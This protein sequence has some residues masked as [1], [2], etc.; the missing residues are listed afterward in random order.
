MAVVR[1]SGR[2]GAPAKQE[3]TTRSKGKK[4][5]IHSDS[6]SDGYDEAPGSTGH[7][8]ENGANGSIQDAEGEYDEEEGGEG[9][10][11][12]VRGAKRQRVDGQ[13]A[14]RASSV[15]E[16][17]QYLRIKT[18][19]RDTDGY[20]PGS[21]MRIQLK[22]FV[23]YDFVQFRCGPYLN[24][25]LGPN[26]TG[27]SSIA[28][29]IALGL[30]FP[31]SILGRANEL[32][33]FVK[34]GMESGYIEIE[35]KGP[36]GK[37]NY[38][39]RRHINAK[40][41]GSTFTLNGQSVAAKEV[42]TKVQELNV[43]VSNLCSFLPQDKVSEFAAMT[44]QQLLRETQRAAGDERLTAWHDTLINSGRELKVV[45]DKVNEEQDHMRLLRE[46][47][48]VV[49]RD[50][51]RFRERKRIEHDISLLEVL[52]PVERYRKARKK[53]MDTKA[54]QRLL[55]T[56]VAMLKE[57]N[58]PVIDLLNKLEGNSKQRERERENMKRCTKEKFGQML[59]QW[60]KCEK[61]DSEADDLTSRIDQRKKDENDRQRRIRDLEKDIAQI[62]KELAAPVKTEDPNDLDK[63]RRQVNQERA[64][65][66]ARKEKIE[67]DV[68][69][70]VDSSSRKQAEVEVAQ[71]ELK[72]LDD[73][74]E[75]KLQNM[76]NWD[77]DTH[78]VILWLRKN[79]H[80]FKMPI[81]EP[82]AIL[83]NVPNK[84]FV[85]PVEA[86]FNSAQLRTFVA[87]CQE[88]LDLFNK[89]VND[90][91]GREFGRKVRVTT[92]FRP[93]RE[94]QLTRPPMAEEELR[95]EGFD[96]YA[97][98]YVDCPKE[99]HWFLK[100]EVNLHRTAIALRP[101]IDVNNVMRLVTRDGPNGAGGGANFFNGATHNIVTRSRY[102][103]RAVAN[104]T[105]EIRPGRTLRAV[106]IDPEV[107][108]RYDQTIATAQQ[109]LAILDEE[110]AGLEADLNVVRQ[111]D[112][113]IEDKLT[114]IKR[115]KDAI[116]E[117]Q[118]RLARLKGKL[119][120]NRRR[121]NELIDMPPLNE[122][123]AELRKN[124]YDLS[125]KRVGIIRE[126][127][128]IVKAVVNEQAECC[129]LGLE[130]LQIS[131]NK[132]ALKAEW[133]KKDERYQQEL[134][135]FQRVDN[136]YKRVKQESKE[137]LEQSRA[138]VAGMEPDL[139][140][141][142]DEIERKRMEYDKA[143]HAAE[144][145]GT[146]S[147]S[148]EGVDVRSLEELQ[149]ELETQKA[150]LE[151]NLATNPHVIEQYERRKEEIE[152]LERTIEEKR[153]RA[154]RFEKNIKTARDNWE[155]AL[156]KLIA[157]IG[158]KFSAAFDRI[159]C[160]GEI[161]ISQH[162]DYDK[163]AID[164]LVKFRDSEKLQ[165]LTGQRQSGGE[166]SLTTILYLMSLTEE[167]RAPFSLVD[168]INQGMDN[169]AERMVHN[170]MVEVTC[171]VDAAQYFLITPKLLPDLEYHERM[172]IL[173]VNN[174]EWLPEDRQLGN[175]MDMVD[176]YVAKREPAA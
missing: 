51:Q 42:T 115:R 19:P 2:F 119:E 48:A 114:D 71:A 17:A 43:Q 23:T 162:E 44:P 30:N 58:Q 35:L 108:R 118:S 63:E 104:M 25:I 80:R 172:R 57:R 148:A 106:T 14:S 32:N 81:L 99:L 67:A 151:L 134:L 163:W 105:R 120:V 77:R 157:S 127:L 132:T 49:E 55:H 34:L 169:R 82:P 131:A 102:G 147:P 36:K 142:Y 37:G 6:D 89:I 78:A 95:L 84:S 24:M 52:I 173:C 87:Q 45:Q 176:H 175:L 128:D 64:G 69:G 59:N 15:Q 8:N 113:L 161:R 140:A 90:S 136:L 171:K 53:F 20:I 116:Q 145:G 165:L 98:D 13:G 160:A 7:V 27:K 152:N 111:E 139:R 143:S 130:S 123:L 153:K 107:K 155:P 41:R 121:L 31:P 137:L 9:E 103:R 86:C 122:Q 72:K 97:L 3:R 18:L 12:S 159:G 110:R 40:S 126:Y 167:A 158:E 65:I 149:A 5:A 76:H 144:Q 93:Q 62:T 138:V 4:R 101:N 74:L 154:M 70:N 38:V 28:C 56:R 174:G 133:E 146:T 135:E 83:V 26:G 85:D 66:V 150:N 164:I 21:I 112:K 50:V 92:W 39:I 75:R 156:E 109:E 94:D 91:Q 124:L 96:G 61:L 11:E 141:E 166:R 10:E 68:R 79:Q 22:N 16:D 88:D 1:N 47:N 170:S 125:R 33:S 46:R 29:A 129:R 60:H 54:Q 117:V 168:E 100:R 73:I